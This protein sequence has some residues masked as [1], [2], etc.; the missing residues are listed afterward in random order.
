MGADTTRFDGNESKKLDDFESKLSKAQLDQK[1]TEIWRKQQKKET[2]K[3]LS[4]ALRVS[5]ELVS[6]LVI[7]FGIGWLL[8]EFF[9]TQPWLMLVFILFGGA[10]G[11]LNVYRHASGHKHPSN[12]INL[13][14]REK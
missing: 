12:I 5:V 1:N 9:G 13:P 11:I 6:A 3:G 8:D 4:L 7:G 2:A 10:A 14:H